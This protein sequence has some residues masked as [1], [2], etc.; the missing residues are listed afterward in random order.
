MPPAKLL[1]PSDLSIS[2]LTDAG[3]TRAWGMTTAMVPASELLANPQRI[4]AGESHSLVLRSDGTIQCYGSNSS[5]QASQTVPSQFAPWM[6]IGVG[7]SHS[8]GVRTNGQVV[9]WGAGTSVPVH[10]SSPAQG[11]SL[12][13]ADLPPATAVAGGSVHSVALLASGAVA[14]WGAGT[15]PGLDP[16][17]F[18]LHQG[19]SVVPAGLRSCVAVAA[20]LFHTVALRADG[21][22]ACWGANTLGECSPPPDLTGVTA[23]AAGRRHTVALRGD[24]SVVCWGD[25]TKG[26]CAPPPVVR[27]VGSVLAWRDMTVAITASPQGDLNHDGT[28]DA[29]DR[30]LMERVLGQSSPP[31]GDLNGDGVADAADRTIVRRNSTDLDPRDDNGDR[32]GDA[33]Q[34][35]DG[36]LDDCDGDGVPE[37]R[38]WGSCLGSIGAF[39][40]ESGWLSADSIGRFVWFPKDPLAGHL[41]AIEAIMLAPNGGWQTTAIAVIADRSGVGNRSI[42]RASDLRFFDYFPVPAPSSP[43]RIARARFPVAPVAL[44]DA[45]AYWVWVVGSVARTHDPSTTPS[46]GVGH[47][48]AQTLNPSNLA[49]T[50]GPQH[51]TVTGA[52]W[53]VWSTCEAGDGPIGDLTGDGRVN[54]ADIGALLGR[55]GTSDPAADL[56][57]NGIVAGGDLAILLGHFDVE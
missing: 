30:A 7:S 8:L 22:V 5:G 1:V 20:G 39:E 16:V 41:L 37:T 40:G 54:G 55:W 43:G 44:D 14:C 13:P 50:I 28:V 21:T 15:D 42:L 6:A 26:Q 51:A 18:P 9:C 52:V 24:G 32:I 33:A 49:A 57:H 35:L 19:Q 12:P 23:I 47:G 11:Q 45:P 2:I 17:E 25:N 53:A 10:L 38:A 46:E 34:L 29:A 48:Y 3:S 27:G 31:L 36:E 56:D 4:C